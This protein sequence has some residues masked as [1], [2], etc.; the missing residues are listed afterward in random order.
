MVIVRSVQEFTPFKLRIRSEVCTFF[1]HG[2]PAP[3][4][5][6]FQSPQFIKLYIM[7]KSCNSYR[8]EKMYRTALW[9]GLLL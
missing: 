3:G 6:T 2:D 9:G 8:P 5:S 4:K 1:N 7:S